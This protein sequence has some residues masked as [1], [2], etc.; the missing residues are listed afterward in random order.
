MFSTPC[1]YISSFHSKS[2]SQ[3]LRF[4]GLI[5]KARQSIAG[6]FQRVLSPGIEPGSWVPQTHILSIKL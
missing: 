2:I 5:E 4:L 1:G 6:L 3:G